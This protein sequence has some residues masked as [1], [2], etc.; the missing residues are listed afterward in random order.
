MKLPSPGIHKSLLLTLSLMPGLSSGVRAE[1]PSWHCSTDEQGRWDCRDIQP[2]TP[3]PTTA[4]AEIV[5]TNQTLEVSESSSE[6]AAALQTCATESN[7]GLLRCSLYYQEPPRDWVNSDRT[8]EASPLHAQAESTIADGMRISLDGRVEIHKGHLQ[9]T[10]GHTEFD[11]ESGVV[12]LDQGMQLRQPGILMSGSK[13]QLDVDRALGRIEQAN[14]ISFEHGARASAALIEREAVNQLLLEKAEYTQCPPDEESWKLQAGKIELD[15]DSG[16]GV[17]RGSVVRVGDVPVFYSPYLNFPIDDR[18]A[19]G[20]LWPSIG[21]N[22]GGLDLSLPVYINIADNMDATL[23]PRFIEQRGELLETEYR[24]MNAVSEWNFSGAY[25]GNDNQTDSKRWLI[26]VEEKGR[27]GELWSTG[28]DFN[29]VSDNDY[30]RDLGISSLA[31]K[32]STHLRQAGNVTFHS[33][34]WESKLQLEQFQTIAD[35]DEPYRRLP[36][37]SAKYRP[38]A[39]NF[40]FE[41][42]F[43]LDFTRFDHPNAIEDGGTEITGDRFFWSAGLSYPMHWAFGHVIPRVKWRQL[44]YQLNTGGSQDEDPSASSAM[45]SIDMGL[46]FE[47][48]SD[49][50]RQSLEPR[51]FWLYADHDAQDGNPNFDSTAL[52]FSYRQLYRDSRFTGLDRLDDAHRATIG[53]DHRLVDR[54]TGRELLF[55]RVGQIFYMRDREVQLPGESVEREDVSSFAASFTAR[56][57]RQH[58]LRSE[59]VW[60]SEENKL[61]SAHLAWQLRR[62]DEELYNAGISYRAADSRDNSLD[63]SL[64]QLDLSMLRPLSDEWSVFG[65]LQQDLEDDLAFERTVGFEYNSCCWRARVVYQQSLEP[66]DDDIAAQLDRDDAILF[67]FQLKGLGGVG[68]KIDKVLEE[69]V[70]GYQSDEDEE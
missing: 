59:V 67:E 19:T 52:P 21:H 5:E 60:Q 25:L 1:V 24:Y 58:R 18:R 43:E 47:K 8:P 61:E 57:K 14:F 15:Y 62:S 35:V 50:W 27:F 44:S 40:G 23:T 68:A 10:A 7:C 64:R 13:A 39:K 55:T 4:D 9:L 36:Q 31:V 22:D 54:Q 30:F 11:R 17:A 51:L 26:G 69:S 37:W 46:T 6:H 28:I 12:V 56:P 45:A 33:G 53:L 42:E 70:F 66:A 2:S 48:R 65:R 34:R 3:N 16:R 38:A 49:R 32:R 41:P 20:I 29:R 63:R